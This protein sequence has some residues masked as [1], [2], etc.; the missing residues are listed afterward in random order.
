MQPNIYKNVRFCSNPIKN[1][2]PN[3]IKKTYVQVILGKSPRGVGLFF[4]FFSEASPKKSPT[5]IGYF[6]DLSNWRGKKYLWGVG[7]FFNFSAE[8]SPKKSLTPWDFFRGLPVPV[9]FKNDKCTNIAVSDI[10]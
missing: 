3:K 4:R 1:R 2:Q 10:F 8:A 9:F 7:L 6:G 5:P